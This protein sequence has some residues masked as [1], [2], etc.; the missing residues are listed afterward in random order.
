VGGRT[1][2]LRRRPGPWLLGVR[3]RRPLEG[4]R[5]VGGEGTA[6][7]WLDEYVIGERFW[8]KA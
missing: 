1:M 6:I 3:R 4:G 5:G 7:E 2:V 8:A